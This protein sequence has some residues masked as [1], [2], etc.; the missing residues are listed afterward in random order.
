LGIQNR[1]VGSIHSDFCKDLAVNLCD[2]NYIVVY[3]VVGWWRLREHLGKY[4]EK[5]RYALVVSIETP[6]VEVDLYTPI[7]TKIETTSMIEIA[8]P[9]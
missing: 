1:D 6:K 2:A 7:I 9:K 5:I 4:D 8:I 3:P